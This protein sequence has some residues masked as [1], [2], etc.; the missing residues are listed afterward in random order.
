MGISEDSRNTNPCY[1]A[2]RT[3]VISVIITLA[4]AI[5]GCGTGG[6]DSSETNQPPTNTTPTLAVRIQAADSTA[7]ANALCTT[8]TPFYW[9]IGDATG[10][11]GGG[12]IGGA[13]PTANSTL[14][15]AS[16]TKWLYGAYVLEKRGGTLNPADIK[17]LTM[18]SGYTRLSAVLC[19]FALTVQGCF[20]AGSNSTYTLADDNRFF[21]DG[22]HFQKNAIDLGLSIY[23]ND[24]LAA[25]FALFVGN[26]VPI[27]FGS[28]QLAGGIA[29]SASSY[30]QFLRKLLNQQ[31]RLG[32][33]LGEGAV[34][35]LP[36]VCSTATSSP[37]PEA[38]HYAYGHWIEDDPTTGDGS[39]SS[40]GAFG[41]YPWIDSSKRYYGILARQDSFVGA[42]LDSV[43]C[44]RV[45]RKAFM[46]GIQQ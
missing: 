12:T 24:D 35:T 4:G 23:E 20:N 18:N 13:A 33:R 22:G 1:A 26:D 38:W 5:S 6:S 45:I 41:F 15:I 10:A 28:P 43:H 7:Q 2:T 14:S 39:F 17:A 3:L 31:L 8:L 19:T 40:P 42:A 11:L 37:I 27:T 25:E 34:C 36:S 44:G 46:T 29:T 21:Y 16:A 9:E 32:A 30:A